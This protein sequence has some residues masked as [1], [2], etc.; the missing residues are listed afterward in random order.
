[1]LGFGEGATFRDVGRIDLLPGL[2][3]VSDSPVRVFCPEHGQLVVAQCNNALSEDP[4]FLA[5]LLRP[6]SRVRRNSL[7]FELL[8]KACILVLH[9]VLG[10]DVERTHLEDVA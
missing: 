9:N 2:P 1:M 8:G 6:F 7:K 10:L 5:L 3:E 4:E